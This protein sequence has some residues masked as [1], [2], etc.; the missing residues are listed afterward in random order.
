MDG[1]AWQATI[2][3]ITES[4]DWV[5]NT[6]TFMETK[7]PECGPKKWEKQKEL[8]TKLEGNIAEK[9]NYLQFHLSYLLKN[10]L[11][12]FLLYFSQL[13]AWGLWAKY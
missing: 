1:G 10:I 2:C 3:G 7:G 11:P 12:P 4:D 13:L 8:M 9:Y 6:L 5:T